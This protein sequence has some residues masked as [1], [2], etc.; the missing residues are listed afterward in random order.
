LK[1][2]GLKF[3]DDGRF[4]WWHAGNEVIGFPNKTFFTTAS[5]GG[6]AFDCTGCHR[7]WMR[8]AG[9]TPGG[10]RNG[11]MSFA[12]FMTMVHAD[13]F[14]IAGLN[15]SNGNPD[16]NNP[17]NGLS[18]Y[19][20]I[21][22]SFRVDK[23]T[24]AFLD[25]KASQTHWMPLK[26]IA[27]VGLWT[28]T[29]RGEYDALA[30]C[31]ASIN[32]QVAQPP[33]TGDG[34][35]FNCQNV[36]CAGEVSQADVVSGFQTPWMRANGK[37][38]D[39]GP[40]ANATQF[41]DSP[42]PAV[43]VSLT[44]IECPPVG[45]PAPNPGDKCFRLAW[46]D[47][48]GSPFNA[49]RT[50]H[51]SRL[52][53]KKV[54]DPDW[55]ANDINNTAY[56]GDGAPSQ[57]TIGAGMPRFPAAIE[58]QIPVV[59]G[60]AW[61]FTYV[62]YGLLPKCTKMALRLCG[63]WCGQQIK[64]AP[65]GAPRNRIATDLGQVLTLANDTQGDV[66]NQFSVTRSGF[67][68][69]LTTGRYVQTVTLKNMTANAIPVP[70]SFVLKNLSANATLYNASG[71]TGAAPYISI[72]PAGGSL[73]IAAGQSVD[74]VLEFVDPSNQAI[75]YDAAITALQISADCK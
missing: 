73:S 8:D 11:L 43:S 17:F 14:A 16:I 27:T 28:N 42:D 29:Y 5:E 35:A 12:R 38:P 47:P 67:R 13:H 20:S 48:S 55:A 70:V 24:Q 59:S 65:E 4:F 69:N 34:A 44:L 66:T 23:P 25:K 71:M 31:G 63:G 18:P 61:R 2:S 37:T 19:Q 3:N 57:L 51:Y 21:A 75:T 40:A 33:N 41:I 36:S 6:V 45:I 49:P 60:D 58:R 68:K 56:C 30:C 7:Y 39:A 32:G 62:S 52:P 9:S 74:V 64:V 72:M 50:F 46:D 1:R 53:D 22:S 54:S 10:E 15:D 26:R